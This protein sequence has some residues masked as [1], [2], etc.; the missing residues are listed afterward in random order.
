M[1]AMSIDLTKAKPGDR[2]RSRD[3]G[4]WIYERDLRDGHA[5]ARR[6]GVDGEAWFEDDGRFVGYDGECRH[7]LVS[8]IFDDLGSCEFDARFD[9][10]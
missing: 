2:Y 8:E 10:N 5:L 1:I 3:G 6:G 7:D 9:G 4:I